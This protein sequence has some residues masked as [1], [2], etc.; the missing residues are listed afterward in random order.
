MFKVWPSMF[1]HQRFMRDW[2]D[3]IYVPFG[4][5]LQYKGPVYDVNDEVVSVRMRDLDQF[6]I[7]TD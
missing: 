6:E 3:Y 1:E 5:D 2:Y 4:L 7:V